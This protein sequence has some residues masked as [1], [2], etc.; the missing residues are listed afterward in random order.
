MYTYIYIFERNSQD[1]FPVKTWNLRFR[2]VL[3][4]PRAPKR[5]SRLTQALSLSETGLDI[6]GYYNFMD[7][8]Y[9]YI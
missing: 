7:M 8:T 1:I 3:A 9:K 6:L 5:M 2:T 4:S